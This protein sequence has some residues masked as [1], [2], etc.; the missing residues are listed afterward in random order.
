MGERTHGAR[1]RPR[2]ERIAAYRE[3]AANLA[4]SEDVRRAAYDEAERLAALS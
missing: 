3:K 1:R 2:E 4:L